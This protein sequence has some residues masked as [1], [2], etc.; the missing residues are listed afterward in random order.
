MEIDIKN[1]R[2]IYFEC[3]KTNNNKQS[4]KYGKL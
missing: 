3:G 1:F 2:R 4:K